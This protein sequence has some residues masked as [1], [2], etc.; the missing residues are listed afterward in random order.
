MSSHLA[1][2][3][4]PQP[5]SPHLNSHPNSTS[6]ARRSHATALLRRKLSPSPVAR[7]V[8]VSIRDEPYVC[9]LRCRRMLTASIIFICYLEAG[10]Q[11]YTNNFVVPN[12]GVQK[13]IHGGSSTVGDGYDPG[14][15]SSLPSFLLTLM[16]PT[17][18]EQ[19]SHFLSFTHHSWRGFARRSHAGRRATICSSRREKSTTT[20]CTWTCGTRAPILTDCVRRR[21][22]ADDIRV[23][24]G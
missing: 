16:D 22:Y 14:S 6:S 12:K 17:R 8:S 23:G 11:F 10:V 9:F 1:P 3:L 19:R 2:Y 20:S 13:K 15:T 4:L 24:E 18:N 7:P 21:L 5:F